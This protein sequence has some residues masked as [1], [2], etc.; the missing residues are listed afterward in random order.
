ML[1]LVQGKSILNYIPLLCIFVSKG[2]TQV[3]LFISSQLTTST[4]PV[5]SSND[6]CMCITS[7]KTP[8][9][10][11]NNNSEWIHKSPQDEANSS[12]WETW[13]NGQSWWQDLQKEDWV[14]KKGH[15]KQTQAHELSWESSPWQSQGNAGAQR[16]LHCRGTPHGL[17]LEETSKLTAVVWGLQHHWA[18]L[19]LGVSKSTEGSFE[20]YLISSWCFPE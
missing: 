8:G 18:E 20:K 11:V 15:C 14:S 16:I 5:S 12:L 10:R 2:Q 1:W 17:P 9:K 7:P 13:V 3:K 6:L 19:P 4:A